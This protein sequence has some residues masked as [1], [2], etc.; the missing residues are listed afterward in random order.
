VKTKRT[1]ARTI[2]D[3]IAGFPEEVRVRLERVRQT[4]LKAAPGA[5]E[6]ISYGIPTFD[7][8]G[9]LIYFA[10]FKQHIGLY[11]APRGA[12]EFA[13]ELAAYEGGKG[14]VRFPS[15]RPLPL[16]LIRRIVKYRLKQ[17]E[18]KA[19]AAKPRPRKLSASVPR[20]RRRRA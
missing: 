7:R 12:A 11:P 20:P 3:Y 18:E 10:G 5:T 16:G 19:K 15:D 17:N 1:A 2:D 9:R 8:H 13:E 14:T 6:A 4:I